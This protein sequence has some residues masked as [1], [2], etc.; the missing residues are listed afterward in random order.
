MPV[1]V[2]LDFLQNQSQLN[3]VYKIR[4]NSIHPGFMATNMN[5]P[6]K[7]ERRDFEAII[8]SIP[9]LSIEQRKILLIAHCILPQMNHPMLRAVNMLLMVWL[10]NNLFA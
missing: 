1:K 8:Q 2:E 7:S 10:L 9:L 3:M 6:K 4:C 5:D